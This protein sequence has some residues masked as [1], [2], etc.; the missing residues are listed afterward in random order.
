MLISPQ[1]ILG[2]LSFYSFPY[3]QNNRLQEAMN[4]EYEY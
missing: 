3:R 1:K 2:F 4:Q